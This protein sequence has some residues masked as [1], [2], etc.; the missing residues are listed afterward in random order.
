MA[1]QMPANRLVC[2]ADR[3]ADVTALLQR[4][5]ALG[6]PADR[7][8]RASHAR[9]L[10]DHDEA[11]WD[12]VQDTPSLGCIQFQLPAATGWSARL[13]SQDIRVARVTLK[14]PTG[15]RIEATVV[16]ARESITQ[17]RPLEW[18]LLTNRSVA[19]PEEADELIAW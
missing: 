8:I 19:T 9:R 6:T 10:A 1:A 18:N 7:L 17:P 3:E 13:V 4:A 11:A 5:Q 15:A 16:R 14:T 2:V 12:Y